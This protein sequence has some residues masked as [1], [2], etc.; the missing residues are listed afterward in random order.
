MDKSLSI[1]DCG[2]NANSGEWEVLDQ[3]DW[4]VPN[5]TIHDFTQIC[6]KADCGASQE[7][8]EPCKTCIVSRLKELVFEDVY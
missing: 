7:Y 1:C 8:R 5:F 4:N 3:R 6:N 2:I